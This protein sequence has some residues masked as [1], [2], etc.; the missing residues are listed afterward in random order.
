MFII[1]Q[2]CRWIF[3]SRDKVTINIHEFRNKFQHFSQ[4]YSKTTVFF[5]VNIDKKFPSLQKAVC[6]SSLYKLHQIFD[7]MDPRVWLY[8]CILVNRYDPFALQVHRNKVKCWENLASSQQDHLQTF[9]SMNINIV[10]IPVL[11]VHM[12]SVPNNPV[13]Y[14]QLLYIATNLAMLSGLVTSNTVSQLFKFLV[15]LQEK[16]ESTL[17]TL[18]CNNYQSYTRLAQA[19]NGWLSM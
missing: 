13:I 2:L 3:E 17:N 9:I 10:N 1:N 11:T 16:Q 12:Q 8:L 14:T 6:Q 18:L 7:I 4:R 15:F 19:L 5:I